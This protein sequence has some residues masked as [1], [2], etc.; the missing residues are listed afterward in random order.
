MFPV[1]ETL[2]HCALEVHEVSTVFIQLTER[3]RNYIHLCYKGNSLK[4]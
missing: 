4:K 2:S 1:H 3:T